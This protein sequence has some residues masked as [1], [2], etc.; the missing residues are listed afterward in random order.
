MK[1]LQL[2]LLVSL[3]AALT[4]AAGTFTTT[5]NSGLPAG[6]HVFGVATVVP[7]GGPDGS[8]CLKM[9]TDLASQNSGFI[10]DDLDAGATINSFTAT[11]QLVLGGTN[12]SLADGLSFNYGSFNDGT[13]TEEGAGAGLTVEFDTYLNT[14]EN[15]GIDVKWNG[16][17]FATHTMT[18]AELCF[19]PNYTNVFIQLTNGLLNVNYGTNVIYTNL[20]IPGFSPLA[21]RFGLGAR[22]GSAMENCWVDNLSIGTTLALHPVL[23]SESP[24][25]TNLPPTPPISVT[26]LDGGSLSQ[27]DWGTLVMQ[28]DGTNVPNPVISQDGSFITL[29]YTPPALPSGSSNWVKV[30]FAD[31][32]TPAVHQTYIFGFTIVNY[33]VIPPTYMATADTGQPGFT[34]RIFQGGTA[35]VN[36]PEFADTMLAGQYFNTA[37]GTLWPNLAQTNTDGTW[38]FT[39]TGTLNYD[40]YAPTNTA[41]A[42]DFGG[43][44]QY[45]GLP[46][47]TNWDL[48]NF[49]Y[50][51]TT[52][53]HLDPGTYTFGV[54]SDD[55]FRL[56]CL[57]KVIGSYPTSGGAH[58]TIFYFSVSQ[59]GDY[60]FRL[61]HF[62]GTGAASLEWFS[63]N[64]DGTK[65]LINDI[66]SSGGIPAY[67]KATTALPYFCFASPTGGGNRPDKPIQVQIQDGVGLHVN[68]SAVHLLV[69]G[70]AVTPSITQAGGVT[71]VQ[72]NGMWASGSANTAM[73][74]FADNEVSPLS[75]TNQFT[76][77][78]ST[79]SSIPASYAISAGAVDTSK[80]GYMQKVFQTDR[81]IS[82]NIASAETM[83][84]GQLVDSLGNPYPNKATANTDGSYNFVQANVL[85]YNIAA[86]ASIGNFTNDT[87]FP[88][89]P[90]I[91]GGTNTFALEN[92]TYLY[93][94]VGYYVLGVTSDD[95]FRLT[96]WPNPHEEFAYQIPG[97]VLDGT[98]SVGETTAGFGITNAGYY[99]FRLVYFQATGPA[100]LELYATSYTGARTLVNDTN[101]AAS[102]RG[103][104]S[105]NNTLPYVQWAY[106]YRA[107]SLFAAAGIPVSFTLVDGTPAIQPST[108][109]MT[110][111][112]ST[113]IPTITRQNG[114]N[115]VV[116]FDPSAYVQTTN[117]TPTVQL[118]W[119]DASGHY[120]TNAFSFTLYGSQALAP[121][122]NLPPGYRPYLTSSGGGVGAQETGLAYNPATG[123]LLLTSLSG[124]STIRGIYI[125]DALTGNDLGQ[126][127]LTN[128]S[129]A[130]PFSGSYPVWGIGVADDGAIYAANLK[131]LGYSFFTYT[132][133]RWASETN[134]VSVAFTDGGSF[135]M[136]V[137]YDFR[138][139]GSGP[140][141][142]I[143]A[144]GGSGSTSFSSA[145]LFTTTDE[146]S[147]T[148]N[149]IPIAN[150]NN[151]LFGGIAFGSN[152]TFYA[153]GFPTTVLRNVAF[154]PTDKTGSATA[155]YNWSAPSGSFGP[156]GVDLV[157]KRVIGLATSLNAGISHTVNLFDLNAL[158]NSMNYPVSTSYVPTANANPASGAG[159]VVFTTN[160]LM[161]FVLDAGNG[162]MAY[163]LAPKSSPSTPTATH[164]S[165]ISITSTTLGYTGGSGSQFV[166]V[167]SATANAPMSSWDR[168]LT[169]PATPGTFTIPAPGPGPALFYRVKSE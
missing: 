132:I 11:F 25:G 140:N 68:T 116:T 152:N 131:S 153:E 93:L 146:L 32:A 22:T 19:W 123:H 112:G 106:P 157:N 63:V 134:P 119:A 105:A 2:V 41:Q 55:G 80:P 127:K 135:T 147:F 24:T 136:P 13:I 39:Q 50:E 113:V 75:Q 21:G 53:L 7:S 35:T 104:R 66:Y 98:R 89:M 48:V 141:T 46:G 92:I 30:T 1:T 81:P 34:E 77:S 85:N 126:L 143:I 124:S 88:G 42:G 102:L 158:T 138:V 38:T 36:T 96:T 23:V 115:V 120:N 37:N 128:S 72:Y 52:Y 71:T 142:Q 64:P 118:V 107:G 57:D 94:P 26:L 103:Y 27:V 59:T 109:Q 100:S 161:A 61:V 164:I 91:G 14:G 108:I 10:L 167:R 133:Y 49:A 67:A 3:T 101:T 151:D 56:T 79:Y 5:F 149:T 18:D 137:G 87:Q 16:T 43:D 76:F 166:L 33:P 159:A 82:Y 70:V 8:G 162:L 28:L 165:P 163:E 144:G 150:I 145:V 83:L 4:A 99:P 17:E 130:S 90:G 47:S 169:N 74:W 154:N 160:G 6:S 148:A 44:I 9:T 20:V 125:L 78:A 139:R 45:P 31:N 62:Q 117:T 168:I 122:W 54:N 69:N 86:P 29:Q 40:I 73:V 155:S 12:A 97:L 95:G 58:D 15:I 111:N 84:A 65:V 110:F 129:G 121:L 156:I 60:P 114:T 51:A